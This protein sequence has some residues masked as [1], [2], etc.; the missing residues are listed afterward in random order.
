QTCALP[1][2]AETDPPC[3]S[4]RLCWLISCLLGPGEYLAV[5]AGYEDASQEGRRHR[6]VAC[7]VDYRS[8]QPAA[9]RVRDALTPIAGGGGPRTFC[10]GH[11]A[12]RWA[13]GQ[14]RLA[15]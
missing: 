12:A 3:T 6:L 8:D 10:A 13:L 15:G 4:G 11:L 2:L 5:I 14:Y 1:I 7:G 9:D